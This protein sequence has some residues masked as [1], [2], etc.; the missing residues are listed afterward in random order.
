MTD[1]AYAVKQVL[2]RAI[3]DAAT[4]IQ[5][6][7][8]PAAKSIESVAKSY[9]AELA[10]LV[11]ELL[12]GGK[13]LSKGSFR[14]KHKALIEEM[15]PKEFREGWE[16]GGGDEQDI[17]REE[18][19][20]VDEFITE[21]QSHVNDF[22]DWLTNKD[23]DLD[24]VP[25]RLDLWQSSMKNLGDIAKAHAQGD[26]ALTYRT[27]SGQTESEDGCDECDEYDGQTHK[28]S[29][30]EQRGLTKRNGNDNFGCGRWGHCPHHF[31]NRK[32]D[33]VIE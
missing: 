18:G 21:Q 26:P 32:G 15:S 5:E 6:N 1:R 28:L 27:G 3:Y 22:S 13:R 7:S 10:E 23:S 17:G 33:M 30:W 19:N 11:Q 4:Y 24:Q 2:A 12:R 9:R 14:A 8:P 20:I 29:W 16:E 25:D 31:Y